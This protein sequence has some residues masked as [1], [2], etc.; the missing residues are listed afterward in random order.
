MTG[1]A[2]AGAAAGSPAAATPATEVGSGAALAIR[3][4]GIVGAVGAAAYLSSF[5]LLSDLSGREAVRSP[6]CVTANMLMAVGYATLALSLGG[7]HPRLP[8]WAVGTAAAGCLAVAAVA[9]GMAT[10]GADVAGWVTDERW[11]EPGAMSAVAFAPKMLLTGVGFAA[12]ALIGRRRGLFTRGATA[13]LGFAAV[14]SAL[15]MPHPPGALIGGLALAWAAQSAET[16]PSAA[17]PAP[18]AR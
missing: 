1:T 18:G 4:G 15:P 11:D 8:R 16:A 14:V 13:L 10:F 12:V 9:W 2:P 5:L 6:L 7:L 17:G 3:I